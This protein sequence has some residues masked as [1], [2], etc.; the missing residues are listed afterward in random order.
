MVGAGGRR[1]GR[2][3]GAS[4][5]RKGHARWCAVLL[6]VL[7]PVACDSHAAGGGPRTNADALPDGVADV[8]QDVP[9]A[10]P[11]IGQEVVDVREGS[12]SE[13]AEAEV[14]DGT[15]RELWNVGIPRVGVVN[16]VAVANGAV[17]VT[18]A[19]TVYMFDRLGSPLG[20]WRHPNNGRLSSPTAV[21][22]NFLV[23]TDLAAAVTPKGQQIWGAPLLVGDVHHD[24]APRPFLTNGRGVVVSL[25]RPGYLD[26]RR[27]V[28][29]ES[30]WR[31]PF[32]EEKI[33]GLQTLVGGF[34]DKVVVCDVAQQGFAVF[35]VNTGKRL[36]GASEPG[37]MA[38]TPWRGGIIAART[39]GQETPSVIAF[40][41]NGAVVMS[42]EVQQGWKYVPQ[43]IDESG[44]LVGLVIDFYAD[45]GRG[46]RLEARS[47]TTGELLRSSDLNAIPGPAEFVTFG[48][49]ADGTVYALAVRA[50]SSL[51]AGGAMIASFDSALVYRE[52]VEF[53]REGLLIHASPPTFT[54]D[55][56]GTLY[57]AL[58]TG[59]GT[60]RLHA[61]KTGSLGFA[62]S[63]MPIAQFDAAATGWAK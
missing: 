28:D 5:T 48:L 44:T 20:D 40:D 61:I 12:A 13:R 41:W 17:A 9:D 62:D 34:E 46:E 51:S 18:S 19:D 52:K 31:V 3:V 8:G 29:G 42:F 10:G 43:Y 21:G 22:G 6:M 33:F 16:Q 56:D 63:P 25:N 39:T 55:D 59:N 4:T 26:G 38:L 24:S 1:R 58:Q 2:D 47:T 57:V 30:L 36:W 45:D 53:P 32:G 23:A 60:G 54:L 35:D 37:I 11:D 14:A 7:P 15:L 49:G 50:A 27:A